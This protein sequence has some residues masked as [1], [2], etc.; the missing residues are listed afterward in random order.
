[1]RVT[2]ASLMGSFADRLGDRRR[3]LVLY[4]AAALLGMLSVGPAEG[5]WA[6]LLATMATTA[7]WNGILPVTDAMATGA[8]R[9][10]EAAY[11]RMRMWGSIAFVATN[12]AGGPVAAAWG[13]RGIW[14]FLVAGFALQFV[15]AFFLPK[16]VREAAPSGARPGMIAGMRIVAADRRLMAVLTGVA[17]LQ[18]SHA[19]LYGFSSLHWASLGFSGGEI[20]VLWALGVI[21]EILLFA[22]SGRVLAVVSPR[23]LVTVGAIGGTV[24]WA[25]FPLLGGVLAPWVAIQGLHAA[26]FAATHL[27]VM[28]IVGRAVDERRAATVQGMMV[29]MNGFAMAIAT[30]ASGPLYRAFGGG[31]FAAMSVLAA[32]GGAILVRATASPIAARDHRG[33]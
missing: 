28:T 19:M 14:L 23:L 1:M 27:G 29:S 15:V 21:G 18:A 30:L 25:L 3:A 33:A 12:L 6:L 11:G 9:R 31:G 8:V 5:F 16:D 17:V 32:V 7:A 4:S 10:G 13:E 2:T 20:G 26:S 22:F 24:R